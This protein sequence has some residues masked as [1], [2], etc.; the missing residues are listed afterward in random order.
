MI[1]CD[2]HAD[3]LFQMVCE[4]EAALDVTL[5]RLQAGGVSL[6]VLAMFVGMDN[7]PDKIRRRFEAML[8]A[9]KGLLAQGWQQAMDPGEAR[10][11]VVKTLLSVE[12]CEIFEP[13][14]E[15]IAEYREK[16]V[17]MAAPTWNYENALG[18]PAIVNADQGL[19]PYGLAAVKEM[20]R[21]QIAVDVSHLNIAGFYDILNKTNAPPLASHSCCRKLR[22]HPRNL[23]DGQLKDLFAAGGFVGL[24]F[25][26]SFLVEAGQPCGIDDLINHIDHMHQLGGQ[27]MVGFGSDFDGITT[28]PQGLE[29][30]A[31]FPALIKG[32]RERGYQENEVESIAG[33]ALLDYYRRLA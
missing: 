30:P 22:D 25:Y 6:Q 7:E 5:E 2:T 24:N 17:R 20:Q 18:V 10:E 29:N 28:K 27:G 21:L 14:L 15:V 26:P 8:L 19:K 9:Y 11:G 1:I 12:G 13:G 3:T 32:L 16:G 33:K 31:D 4:P 23:T